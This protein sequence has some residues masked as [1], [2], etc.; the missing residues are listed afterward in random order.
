MTKEFLLNYL[1]GLRRPLIF[2]VCVFAIGIIVGVAFPQN[3]VFLIKSISNMA[4]NAMR[5]GRLYLVLTI[6]AQNLMAF[7]ILILTGALFGVIPTIALIVNGALIGTAFRFIGHDKLW[8]MFIHILP[9]GIF[10]L[11]AYFFCAAIA[12][13]CGQAS[14]DRLGFKEIVARWRLGTRVFLWIVV[15][16]LIIAAF[17]EAFISSS[18]Y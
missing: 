8:I 17:I 6:L 18:N 9:H 5:H 15:P 3:F 7:Y 12:L 16:L 4:A 14:L 1:R 11:P 2:A 10:E 13:H